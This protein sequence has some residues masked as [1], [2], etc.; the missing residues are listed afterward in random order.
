M[1]C[2]L[3]GWAIFGLFVGAIARLLWPDR[4]RYGAIGTILV[5]IAG[6]VVGGL[7]TFL[8]RGGPGQE[9]QP[10]GFL[11]SILG[12]ILVLWFFSETSDR[13]SNW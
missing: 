1:L 4:Q 12:A 11:M 6:S 3:F 10:A 9:Y 8:L 2:E 5:G 13:P 7:L